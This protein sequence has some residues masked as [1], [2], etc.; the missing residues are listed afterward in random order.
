MSDFDAKLTK[1]L[2]EGL[3][4]TH[5]RNADLEV[6][7]YDEDEDDDNRRSFSVSST[8]PAIR[9]METDEG[10]VVGNE[11]LSH[12]KKAVKLDRFLN[13]A[14]VLIEHNPREVVG[15]IED[16]R[17]VAG[18]KLDVDMRFSKNPL[19]QEIKTDVD[20]KIRTQV[21]IGYFVNRY[22][23]REDL[24]FENGLPTYEAIDWTPAEASFVGVAAD[25]EVGP[26]RSIKDIIRRDLHLTNMDDEKYEKVYNAVVE[27]IE[28]KNIDD[29]ENSIIIDDEKVQTEEV[30]LETKT[31]EKEMSEKNQNETPEVRVK[32]DHDAR[33]EISEIY[34][35]AYKYGQ[36]DK[37]DEWVER[38]YNA[39]QVARE[40]LKMKQERRQEI[41]VTDLEL[42]EKEVKEYNLARGLA[43]VLRGETT[44][45]TEVSDEI[46]KKRKTPTGGLYFPTT[47][48][49]LNANLGSTTGDGAE[50]V[51]QYPG[52]FID[53]L[54]DKTILT[55]LGATFLRGL[56]RKLA[57]PRQT[58]N[59]AISWIAEDPSTG[60]TET[61]MSLDQVTIEP[62]T[63]AVSTPYT[64]Q[65]LLLG[66]WDVGALVQDD[67]ARSFAVE[68]ESVAF[69]GGS[70]NQPTGIVSASG[71]SNLTSAVTSG[72]RISGQIVADMEAQLANNKAD[73][74]N[75]A[76]VTTPSV[77]AAARHTAISGSGGIAMPIWSMDNEIYGYPAYVST[78]VP[79]A[80]P[81]VGLGVPS[82]STIIMGAWQDLMVAEFGAV[83][84]ILDELTAA[85]KAVIKL[86]ALGYFDVAVRHPASFVVQHDIVTY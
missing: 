43:A 17:T 54:R 24:T 50:I 64:R 41:D 38:G 77:R 81:L 66:D 73:I 60:V 82:G 22:K 27:L 67:Q 80:N 3:A 59:A 48:R 23:K 7:K 26:G 76:F 36:Q 85:N 5:Y 70:T 14:S 29:Q 65:L 33:K 6:R 12:S 42:S 84:F 83:E 79:S 11:V 25:F 56:S 49:S 46:A 31:Q 34:D 21:S 71:V 18:K 30:E 39:D 35:L 75:I 58:S 53:L 40:I 69:E 52:D 74:G 78:L 62:K 4:K 57:F 44:F 8:A 16:A 9:F 55:P 68:L 10:F 51:F 32:E 13:G 20:D 28:K 19:A 37:L 47:I 2:R 63:L 72:S 61:T 45:E 1:L 15:V 86:T